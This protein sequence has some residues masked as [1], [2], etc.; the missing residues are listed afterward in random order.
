MRHSAEGRREEEE[1]GA[2]RHHVEDA[3]NVVD[4]GVAVPSLISVVEPVE[5][6]HDDPA[7]QC[8]EEEHVLCRTTGEA[9]SVAGHDLGEHEGQCNSRHVGDRKEAPQQPAA[10]LDQHGRLPPFVEGLERSGVEPPGDLVV[11][12]RRVR[13]RLLLGRVHVCSSCAEGCGSASTA[14]L[15][16]GRY[17][18]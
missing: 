1:P 13:E 5:L 8:G 4:R 12:R 14:G 15:A 9:T 10:V 16:A 18:P 11:V 7:R 17:A 3:G 2:A 6:G